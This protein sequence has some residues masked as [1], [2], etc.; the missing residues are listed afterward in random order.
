MHKPSKHGIEQATESFWQIRGVCNFIKDNSLLDDSPHQK[1]LQECLMQIVR[2]ASWGCEM[3]SA[4][5]LEQVWPDSV[6]EHRKKTKRL[7]L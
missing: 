7:G 2:A 6:M 1:S 5:Q 3:L 4:E